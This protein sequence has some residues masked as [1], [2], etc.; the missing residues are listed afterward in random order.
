M[1]YVVGIALYGVK[2]RMNI[3]KMKEKGSKK[4]NEEKNYRLFK[5]CSSYCIVC[6]P[7]NV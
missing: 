2:L 7:G 6:V 3:M 5:Q 4:K 1:N